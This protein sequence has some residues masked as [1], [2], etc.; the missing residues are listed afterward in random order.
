MGEQRDVGKPRV[1]E[2]R[3]RR[4]DLGHL[5]QRER[6]LLHPGA[7]RTGDHDQRDPGVAGRLHRAGD[8]LAHHDAHAAADERVLHDGEDH[9]GPLDLG[10]HHDD[11]VVEAG[12]FGALREPV[13]V[14]HPV[15]ETEGIVGA[16]AGGNLPID[17]LVNQH[18]DALARPEPQVEVTPGADFE[19]LPESPSVD[20]LRTPLAPDEQALR[21]L[22]PRPV[23]AA[24]AGRGG[25][26]G[27][28][29]EAS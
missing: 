15:A 16:D 17:P 3:E 21:H 2:H 27:H 7:A 14:F 5:H 20:D 13:A 26:V 11:G 12:L 25:A 18:L 22:G 10:A 8:L 28:M 1:V 29:S 19:V 6:A 23:V 9:R 24:G 4:R